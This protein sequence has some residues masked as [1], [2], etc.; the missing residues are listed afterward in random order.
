MFEI[1]ARETTGVDL[2]PPPAEGVGG[3]GACILRNQSATLP[4][5]PPAG[6]RGEVGRTFPYTD[7]DSRAKPCATTP[8]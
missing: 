1:G 6:G 2:N 3:G 4:R 7:A 5:S 8:G